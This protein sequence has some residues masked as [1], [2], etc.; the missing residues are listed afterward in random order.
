[1]GIFNNSALDTVEWASPCSHC[2]SPGSSTAAWPNSNTQSPSFTDAHAPVPRGD[3]DKGGSAGV[4]E[5]EERK[6]KK[7]MGKTIRT[8]DWR[9]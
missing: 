3:V 9:G 8:K 1:M 4:E 5:E 6:A 7:S 2:E